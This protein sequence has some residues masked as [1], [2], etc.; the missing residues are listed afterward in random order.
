MQD[1]AIT[2]LKCF[3]QLYKVSKLLRYVDVTGDVEK[4]LK[5]KTDCIESVFLK[6]IGSLCTFGTLAMCLLGTFKLY[7]WSFFYLFLYKT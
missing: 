1:N 3:A 7:F 6:I 2:R 5:L 4:Y